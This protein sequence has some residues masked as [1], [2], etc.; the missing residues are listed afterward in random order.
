MPVPDDFVQ[1]GNCA[2][3]N[4]TILLGRSGGYSMIGSL[5]TND[6][7]T[8]IIHRTSNDILQITEPTQVEGRLNWAGERVIYFATKGGA[9]RINLD[10][11]LP[12]D[13]T[14]FDKVTSLFL[15]YDL[16]KVEYQGESS[17][18]QLESGSYQIAARL[19]TESGASTSFGINT[20]PIPVV[21][22]S[23]QA[24]R[25]DVVGAPPQTATAKSCLLYTSPSPR[26][27]G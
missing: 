27:R 17:S 26:D 3:G 2:I 10:S 19:V 18:G 21:P 8:T 25:Q 24:S 6:E 11:T 4:E 5:N 20:N 15:E 7:W 22:T 14:E 1:W 12:A 16:P 23:L 13:D 9:R